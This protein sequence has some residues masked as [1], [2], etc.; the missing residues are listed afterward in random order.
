MKQQMR[1]IILDSFNEMRIHSSS[2]GI[3]LWSIDLS[4]A[5]FLADMMKLDWKTL[6]T[7]CGLTTIICAML[8]TNHYCVVPSFDEVQRLKAWCLSRDISSSNIHFVIERSEHGL[9]KLDVDGYDLAIIDGRHAFPTP[10]IDF[11]FMAE[12]L[13]VGGFLVIDDTCLWTGR[14][15]SKFF[16]RE[17]EWSL[18]KSFCNTI[19][20]L[21]VAEG[22][23]EKNCLQQPYFLGAISRIRIKLFHLRIIMLTF[24]RLLLK[25]D[26]AGIRTRIIN[27]FS[28]LFERLK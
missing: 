14:I 15:L 27:R 5:F 2:R 10:F 25:A 20:F 28:R 24:L 26:F 1:D 3:T 9:P 11:Y 18:I 13:K 8:G 4:V 6:E 19:I 12:R 17:K 22:T 21:K 16:Q 7:G 23:H